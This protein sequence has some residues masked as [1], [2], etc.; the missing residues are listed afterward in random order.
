LPILIFVCVELAL[1]LAERL[2][3][4]RSRVILRIAANTVAVL[5][6]VKQL[7]LELAGDG[8]TV[9]GSGQIGS[10]QTGRE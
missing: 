4:G 8:L 5:D 1:P 7:T 10:F 3:A 9:N 6:I 2:L